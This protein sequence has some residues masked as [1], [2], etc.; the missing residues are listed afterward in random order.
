MKETPRF[1]KQ[2]NRLPKT[3]KFALGLLVGGT[4]GCSAAGFVGREVTGAVNAKNQELAQAEFNAPDRYLNHLHLQDAGNVLYVRRDD[5][6][7]TQY[8]EETKVL[9][10]DIA[11]KCG[12]LKGNMTSWSSTRDVNLLVGEPN[13]SAKLLAAH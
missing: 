13:C 4:I 2:L 1:V 6:W 3:V 5:W 11:D 10:K 12:G 8:D 7:I 9:F